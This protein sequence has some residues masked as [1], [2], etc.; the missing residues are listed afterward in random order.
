M[1][2]LCFPSGSDEA[3]ES[4]YFTICQ[5]EQIHHDM[6]GG[7][8]CSRTT[9]IPF[10]LSPSYSH[11]LFPSHQAPRKAAPEDTVGYGDHT[12][13]DRPTTTAEKLAVEGKGERPTGGR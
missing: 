3:A 8:I 13:R 10:L 6:G 5:L 9:P 2:A 12:L 1:L 11:P 4:F 7:G